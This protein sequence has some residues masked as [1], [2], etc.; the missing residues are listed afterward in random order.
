MK[1]TRVENARG[2][3]K[4]KSDILKIKEFPLLD[5]YSCLW[6]S[7]EVVF[8]DLEHWFFYFTLNFMDRLYQISILWQEFWA[9]LGHMIHMIDKLS[10]AAL[11][12]YLNTRTGISIKLYKM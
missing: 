5:Q 4:T 9:D 3:E 1:E 12:F 2:G 8:A 10:I 7:E 11:V 6:R